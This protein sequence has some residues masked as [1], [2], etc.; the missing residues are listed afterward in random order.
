MFTQNMET[1]NSDAE[2]IEIETMQ[3]KAPTVKIVKAIGV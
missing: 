3:K 1:R 2:T